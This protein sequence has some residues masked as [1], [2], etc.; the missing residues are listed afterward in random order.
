MQ[1]HTLATLLILLFCQAETGFSQDNSGN[2]PSNKNEIGKIIPR[3]SSEI[4]G[5]YWGVQAGVSE[6]VLQKASE[7]GIK[8]TRFDTHWEKIEKEKGIYDWQ[9]MDKA[10]S[11]FKYGITPFV[12]LGNGNR[13]YS[14]TGKFDDP[15]QAAI[16]GESPAPPVGSP[17]EMEAWLTF[18]GKVVERYKDNVFY[19]EIWNE[20]N[21]Q[22]YWGAIPNGKDY[23]RLVK[24]TAEK[25]RSIQPNAKII[26]GATAGLHVDYNGD[27]LSECDPLNIDIISFHNY[28]P[29]PEVRIYS[30][31]N[32][33]DLLDK[34]NPKLEI[35]QGECGY[36]SHSR[37]TGYRGRA[38]WGLNIQAKWLLRQSFVDTYFCGATLSSYYLL[39]YDKKRVT[40]DSNR[41]ELTGLDAVLGYPERNG[42]RVHSK[43]IN[44]KCLLSQETLQPKPAYSAYQNL[45]SAMDDRY[46]VF[47]TRYEIRVIH[48]G[49][50]YG[51]GDDED[52]FP[53]VPLL[54]SYKTAE[55]KAFVAYWLPWN[56]QENVLE[57]ASVSLKI[58]NAGF[59]DPVLLD[60][61]TGKVYNIAG[62]K[63]E[64]GI[65]HFQEIPLSD[66]PFAL[67]E[68]NEINFQ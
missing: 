5:S 62:F 27:F 33:R 55:G 65:S 54:A 43:G 8:W 41:R 6:P 18:V 24:A 19:W 30:I 64:N 16:Y 31:K 38:P 9:E 50:F 4:A 45:C 29:L 44:E 63:A 25:I 61:L 23:G 49:H 26:A 35:W 21:H 42:S 39:A 32:F 20:P 60:L 53:S 40:P 22:G 48:E 17:E 66:Y 56:P 13:L 10:L 28:S 58:D 52:A 47:Q 14:G 7:L 51:I 1:F 37:T 46:K 3:K 11:V 12:T 36:P 59:D 67:V 2:L 15:K 57:P 34:H 68:R